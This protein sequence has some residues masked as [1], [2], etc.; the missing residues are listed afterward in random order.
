MKKRLFDSNLQDIIHYFVRPT[1]EFVLNSL[2]KL[3]CD[4]YLYRLL[5]EEGYRRV[6]FFSTAAE[7][8]PVYTYDLLSQLSYL[9][10]DD[11]SEVNLDDPKTLEDFFQKRKKQEELNQGG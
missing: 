5:R 10:P 1:D 11:F 9:K 4:E 2:E 3:D 7:D 8:Y 6:V